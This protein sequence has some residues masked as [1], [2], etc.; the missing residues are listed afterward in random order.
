MVSGGGGERRK[1]DKKQM[2]GVG[3]GSAFPL[4]RGAASD[5]R[6]AFP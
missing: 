4:T 6:W 1:S 3:P 2:K 5:G